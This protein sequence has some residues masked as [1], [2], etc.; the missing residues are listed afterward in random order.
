MAMLRSA[1]N[2]GVKQAVVERGLATIQSVLG[3]RT[4]LADLSSDELETASDLFESQ[5][6][7]PDAAEWRARIA[8]LRGDNYTAASIMRQVRAERQVAAERTSAAAA[9][10][11][12]PHRGSAA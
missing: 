8:R 12:V 11:A 1:G 4:A 7:N 3:T 5:D 2:A 6:T 10:R 9:R